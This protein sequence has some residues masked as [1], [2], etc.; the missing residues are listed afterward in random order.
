MSSLLLPALERVGLVDADHGQPATLRVD[1]VTRPGELL[2]LLQARRPTALVTKRLELRSSQPVPSVAW[3]RAFAV[4]QLPSNAAFAA[5][6]APR[7][8]LVARSQQHR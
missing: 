6:C 2:L 8:R 5:G 3:I 4:Q 7:S 1:P